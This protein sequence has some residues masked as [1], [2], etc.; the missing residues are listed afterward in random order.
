MNNYDVKESV[1]GV[2]RH[3]LT[4]AGTY[5]AAQGY[6]TNDTVVTIVSGLVA[7]AG[8]IWSIQNKKV[9]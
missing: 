8:L 3:V 1:L 4:A 6:I 5:F 9:V 7:L 2:F